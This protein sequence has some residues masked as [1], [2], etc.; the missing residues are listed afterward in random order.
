MIRPRLLMLRVRRTMSSHSIHS[1]SGLHAFN[2]Q[3][4]HCYLHDN[5]ARRNRKHDTGRRRVGGVLKFVDNSTT[6]FVWR[7]H[8]ICQGRTDG[9]CNKSAKGFPQGILSVMLCTVFQGDWKRKWKS[10]IISQFSERGR[11]ILHI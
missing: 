4:P 2:F 1:N 6:V 5:F 7:S 11:K 9:I 3:S 10:R 8:L